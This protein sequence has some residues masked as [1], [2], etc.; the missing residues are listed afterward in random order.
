MTSRSAW[1]VGTPK[2]YQWAK[3]HGS[4]SRSFCR[5]DFCYVESRDRHRSHSNRLV[6]VAFGVS[7]KTYSNSDAENSR[8]IIHSVDYLVCVHIIELDVPGTKHRYHTVLEHRGIDLNS[9]VVLAQGQPNRLASLAAGPLWGRRRYGSNG[10][11]ISAIVSKLAY[12]K[13]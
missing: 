11:E 4:S 13:V 2:A 8:R 7:R 9:W 5:V 10:E 6:L 3:F 12:I 1:K